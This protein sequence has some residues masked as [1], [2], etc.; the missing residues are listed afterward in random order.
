MQLNTSWRIISI[1]WISLLSLSLRAQT[2]EQTIALGDRM[3]EAGLYEEAIPYYERVLFFAGSQVLPE[4]TFRMAESCL[5][6]GR[7]D[8]ALL[9]Y[10]EAFHLNRDP[11]RKAEILFSRA[12][13][14]LQSGNPSFA[15]IEL[16]SIQSEGDTL[17]DLRKL[18]Y[19]GAV[20]MRMDQYAAAEKYFTDY[21]L[22]A[23]F[24]EKVPGLTALMADTVLFSRINPRLAGYFSLIIPGSGQLYAGEWKEALNSFLLVGGLQAA[25]IFISANYSLLDAYLGIFPWWQRYYSGGYKA[26]KRLAIEKKNKLRD[27][28]YLNILEQ[29]YQYSLLDKNIIRN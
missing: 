4:V 10:D 28:V 9:Y 17:I 18:F 5:A 8:Q 6:A 26:A 3:F 14:Y 13:A 20:K 1:V 16:L 11:D 29:C 25:F 24:P 2:I 23:G 19:L 15:L 21:L 22:L 7:F 27:E 12:G